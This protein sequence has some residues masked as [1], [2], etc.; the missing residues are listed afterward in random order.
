MTEDLSFMDPEFVEYVRSVIEQPLANDEEAT[1]LVSAACLKPADEVTLRTVLALPIPARLNGVCR[2]GTPP[3]EVMRR[4]V[5]AKRELTY[6]NAMA[7]LRAKWQADAVAARRRPHE[8]GR[9]EKT[10][11]ITRERG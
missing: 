8:Q 3:A 1:R 7:H 9:N 5:A 2:N 11:R 4:L 10:A 6:D